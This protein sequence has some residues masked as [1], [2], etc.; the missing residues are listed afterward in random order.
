MNHNLNCIYLLFHWI[1]AGS[2]EVHMGVCN[3]QLAAFN[4]RWEKTNKEKIYHAFE[5]YFNVLALP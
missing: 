5:V 1:T 3:E 4:I 2:T